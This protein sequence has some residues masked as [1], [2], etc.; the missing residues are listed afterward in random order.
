MTQPAVPGPPACFSRRALL[1]ALGATGVA[2]SLVAC[3]ADDAGTTPARPAD[4]PGVAASGTSVPGSGPSGEPT[5]Q[6]VTSTTAVPVGGGTL[7]AGLLVVQPT[8][9]RFAA[10]DAR[11]PHRGAP[12]SPPKAGVVT[13]QEHNS[14]FSDTDGAL[15]SG[16]ARRGLRQV[17]ITV[18][19]TTIT[20]TA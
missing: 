17:P 4:A 5:Q 18:T 8:A 2:A 15:L 16:P 19:G 6:V 1:S 9:G 11:C 12:I 3:Q 14:T 10:F 13:C 7:V 20:R